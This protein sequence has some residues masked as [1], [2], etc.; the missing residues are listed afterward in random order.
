[1]DVVYIKAVSDK[2]ITTKED[3]EKITGAPIF[4]AIEGSN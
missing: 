1:M 3:L 4:A 2:T